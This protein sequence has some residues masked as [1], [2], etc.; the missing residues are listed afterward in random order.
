MTAIRKKR[1]QLFF[2][3]VTVLTTDYSTS[4]DRFGF[5]T[6][7]TCHYDKTEALLLR[8]IRI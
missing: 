5:N 8:T 7:M 2:Q 1:K 6:K 3:C 4:N